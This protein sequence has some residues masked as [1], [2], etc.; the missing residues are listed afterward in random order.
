LR[1]PSPPAPNPC[2]GAQE[3]PKAP[4][5]EGS[6]IERELEKTVETWK[7]VALFLILWVP[8]WVYF[9][10]LIRADDETDG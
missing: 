8:L 2:F 3:F 7:F 4:D 5:E 10:T 9:E 1:K 6:P